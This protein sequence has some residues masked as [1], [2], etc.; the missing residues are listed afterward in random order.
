MHG[1][2]SF[3]PSIT[4]RRNSFMSGRRPSKTKVWNFI[5]ALVGCAAGV[6]AHLRTLLALDLPVLLG[7]A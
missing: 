4:P 6:R 3:L 7:A 1:S 2:E 5:G